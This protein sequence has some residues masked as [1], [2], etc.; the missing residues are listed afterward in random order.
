[1]YLLKTAVVAA[2]TCSGIVAADC[3][4]DHDWT[5]SLLN[6]D[7]FG[8]WAAVP[9]D[10]QKHDLTKAQ[11]LV[12]KDHT[13]KPCSEVEP[14]RIGIL[15]NFGSCTL[16]WDDGKKTIVKADDT[17]APGMFVHQVDSAKTVAA[18]KCG[19]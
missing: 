18:M 6:R 16:Y 7:R 9:K 17:S 13:C 15:N 4:S 11:C 8:Y 14:D 10:G 3:Y 5:I 2:L 19:A 1:M 12:M